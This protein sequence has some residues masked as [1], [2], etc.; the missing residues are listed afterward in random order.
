VNDPYP[1]PNREKYPLAK[2]KQMETP[3]PNSQVP[4]LPD[5]YDQQD[6]KFLHFSLENFLDVV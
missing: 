6:P 2:G 3:F 5:V 1:N 4:V